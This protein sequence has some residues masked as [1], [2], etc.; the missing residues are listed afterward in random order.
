[1]RKGSQTGQRRAAASTIRPRLKASSPPSRCFAPSKRQWQ[2]MPVKAESGPSSTR[3]QAGFGHRRPD[4]GTNSQTPF[5]SSLGL[6]LGK[7]AARRPESFSIFGWKRLSPSTHPLCSVSR[8]D[9]R[10]VLNGEDVFHYL[11]HI[12]AH[13]IRALDKWIEHH[14]GAGHECG[15]T[16]CA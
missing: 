12:S 3:F 8:I 6:P 1:M 13:Y 2:C 14:A 16:A 10:S 5:P 4:L 15:R 11:A 7:G 9:S